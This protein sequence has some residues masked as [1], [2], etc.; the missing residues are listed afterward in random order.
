MVFLFQLSGFLF[1]VELVVSVV[2]IAA[3]IDAI[4]RN[5]SLFVVAD[6]QTKVLWLM[7][8]VLCLAVGFVGVA[9]ALVYFLDVR[10]ALIEAGS[11]QT[12]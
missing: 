5:G 8:L 2:I 1:V 7:L 9:G 3:L 6:K 4:M 10:P 11:G 12:R